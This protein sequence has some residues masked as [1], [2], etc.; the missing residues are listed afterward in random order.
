MFRVAYGAASKFKYITQAMAKISDEATVEVS[1][2]EVKFW[3]MS[4]DKTSLAIFR[5]PAVSLD[6]LEVDE[7]T[8]LVIRADEL[9]KLVKRATRNDVLILEY[10]PSSTTLKLSLRDRKHEIPRDFELTIVDTEAPELKEPTFETTTRF[11]MEASAFKVIVQDAKVV[12][13]VITFESTENEEIIVSVR[14]E[15]K[16][17]TWRLVRGRPL[18]DIEVIEPSRASYTRA[19]LEASAKPTGAAERTKLEYATDHPLKI[20]YSFPNAEKMIIYIAPTIE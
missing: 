2:D 7:E 20:E 19:S 13:D 15:E 10:D 4:P 12:G 18:E 9:N 17:Y 3:L 16:E 8:R 5:I 14:G 6:E 1:S 11:V